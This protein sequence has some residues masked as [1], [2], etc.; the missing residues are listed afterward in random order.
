MNLPRPTR[1]T[2]IAT[3][4]ASAAAV[5][6]IAGTTVAAAHR[7]VTVEV[8][9][10]SVPVSG[11]LTDV[12]SVLAAS[13]IELGEHDKVAPAIDTR[14]SDG[15]IVVVRTASPH[16]LVVDGQAIT[17]WSTADTVSDVIAD[18]VGTTTVAMP[19][20]RSEGRTELSLAATASTVT[21]VADGK[22]IPVEAA[23][24]DDAEAI[25]AKAG[26]TASAIDRLSFTQG[27]NGLVLNVTRVSRGTQTT[28]ETIAFQTEEREDDTLTEGTTEVIQEGVDG[29]VERTT[30]RETIDGEVTVEVVGAEKRTEP[31][32]KI[33]RVGTKPAATTSS[34]SSSTTSTSTAVAT[35]DIW[36]QL[37]L[38]ESGGNPSINTG[39]GYYGMYQFS[40]PTWYSVGGT[41]LPSENS[42]EEQTYRAQILQARSG[43]GQWPACAASL[44]LL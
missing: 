43:W 25:L 21:V 14:V 12:S 13:G 10:V 31:V 19:A 35:G 11:F 30:Y 2:I 17:A 4:A 24:T 36:W 16:T 40:L 9:G 18:T 3:A 41:G 29:S 6:A 44:G 5:L 20:D 39:N 42:A 26:V 22:E 23:A 8:D 33:V 38:C 37:A 1:R 34:S 7:E 27:E 28:T 15:Q 32:T